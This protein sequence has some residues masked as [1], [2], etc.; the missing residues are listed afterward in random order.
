MFTPQ[1][2]EELWYGHHALSWLLLPLSWLYAGFALLLRAAYAIGI[3]PVQRVSVPVIVVG[4]LTVGGTGKTPLVIWMADYLK[5]RGL[6]PGIVSRGYGGTAKQWPQQVRPDSNP[7]TVG[8]EPVVIARRTGCPVAISPNRYAAASELVQH[9][10]CDIILCDD[11]LQHLELERDL[12][13]AVIDGVRQFGNGR[14]LPAGPLREPVSRLRSVDMIVGKGQAGKNQFL[15]EYT[16]LRLQS[17]NRE[18]PEYRELETFAGKTVH[19]VAGIGNPSTFFALL[20]SRGVQTIRHVFPDHHRY[21]PEELNFDDGLPVVM[22]EKDA[23]KCEGFALPDMW[24]LPIQAKMS[25]AFEHRFSILIQ[26]LQRG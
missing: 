17:L 25:N 24:F 26:E 8:D 1:F 10:G 12:E 16:A 19:A 21:R 13:I 3:L 11:G 9:T 15:M 4:N 23:V 22:T 2:I 5:Q 20:R 6:H 7:L 18:R 14:C